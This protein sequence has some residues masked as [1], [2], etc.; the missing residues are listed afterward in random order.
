MHPFDPA[1]NGDRRAETLLTFPLNSY[2]VALADQIGIHPA[3]V[4]GRLHHEGMIPND[5]MNGF[6]LSMD[7][8]AINLSQ[9]SGAQSAQLSR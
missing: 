3:I 8:P 5:W 6:K 9:D 2:V 1:L 7:R 4:V